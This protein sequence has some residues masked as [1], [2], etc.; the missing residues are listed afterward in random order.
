MCCSCIYIVDLSLFLNYIYSRSNYM[1][2]AIG[3]IVKRVDIQGNQKKTSGIF[4]LWTCL[5]K[6]RKN[7]I[8]LSFR[9]FTRIPRSFKKNEQS[10]PLQ[11]KFDYLWYSGFALK[12][13]A[14]LI[15]SQCV[16]GIL[17]FFLEYMCQLVFS[18]KALPQCALMCCCRERK[19]DAPR[20]LRL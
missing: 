2:K 19:T 7:K 6:Y 14:I 16:N 9:I 17:V 11:Y 1:I 12:L 15:N 20:L 18:L 10:T 5:L 8:P 3:D 13:G 4:Q